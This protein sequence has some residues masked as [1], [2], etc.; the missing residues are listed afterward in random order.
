MGKNILRLL[1]INKKQSSFLWGARK[2]GKSH[3]IKNNFKPGEI[4]LIDLLKTDTFAEYAS[5]PALLRERFENTKKL[6]VLDEIQKVPLLLD[7]VHWMIENKKIR[8]LLTGSSARKLRRNHA[9]LLAG[10]AIRYEM[11]PFSYMEVK[12]KNLE[13]IMISGM[14]PPHYLST[15]PLD[16]IRSYF[17]DY[18]QEEIANEAQIQKI[19]QFSQFLKI[20]A[21]TSGEMLNYDNVARES[22]VSSK[23]V[24]NYFDILESTMLGFRISPW[25][26]SKNRRLISAE[27]FYLFDTGIANYL[28]RR[29]PAE[30]TPEFGKSFEHFILMELRAYRAYRNPELEITYWRTSTGYEVDFILDDKQVALEI[31]SSRMVHDI[32]L[33]SLKA[34]RED[35]QIKH[36]VIVCQESYPRK[37]DGVKILP[38]QIFLEILWNKEFGI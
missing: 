5:R 22:G 24:R 33:K 12:E 3:W 35:G 1:N 31:K 29:K 32:D 20:A 27:K 38:W 8:F 9:N 34:L 15:E 6:I 18:L 16:L 13:K 37:L 19:P 26:S 21:I 11:L 30:G 10:R 17:A 23:V 14:L 4:E 25:R 2:T 28:A 36:S 7:E